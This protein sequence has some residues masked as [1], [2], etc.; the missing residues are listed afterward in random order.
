[1][2]ITTPSIVTVAPIGTTFAMPQG[3]DR[4][5]SDN[6]AFFGNHICGAVAA[7]FSFCQ[8]FN[9][10]GSGKLVYADGFIVT[11]QP[12]IATLFIKAHTA[13]LTTLSA[14]Q[15]V[16]R[17]IGGAAPSAQLRHQNNA[18][19][20]GADG[21]QIQVSANLDREFIFP[22]P[23]RIGEGLGI[24]IQHGVVNVAITVNWQFREY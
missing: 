13:Q 24:H 3:N 17:R 18:G 5:V 22:W 7:Q 9:P 19:G 4:T 1:M 11:A 21:L 23:I 2:K 20:I 16:S 6:Q 8:L 10:V 14:L 12:A 15:P